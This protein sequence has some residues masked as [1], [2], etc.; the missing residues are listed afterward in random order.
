MAPIWSESELKTLFSNLAH[1]TYYR[2]DFIQWS[3]RW[4]HDHCEFC[5]KRNSSFEREKGYYSLDNYHWICE[6]C[7]SANKDILDLRLKAQK[8]KY[9]N[10]IE[11]LDN[12][13]GHIE[14]LH[15]YGIANIKKL[16]K[17][18][19]GVEIVFEELT[20]Y[21][22]GPAFVRFFPSPSVEPE[23][24]LLPMLPM[25]FSASI[26]SLAKATELCER[27]LDANH[28]EGYMYSIYV[29]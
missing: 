9:K 20:Q 15:C 19:E 29:K 16:I 28:K 8:L 25:K 23:I 4:D 12:E 1:R 11:F 7:F 27:Q 18:T 24:R 10:M 17:N 26:A 13:L 21:D 22:V 6:E 14:G 2:S 3:E 5:W